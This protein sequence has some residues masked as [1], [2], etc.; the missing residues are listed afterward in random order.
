MGR[1][2][3]LLALIS[4]SALAACEAVPPCYELVEPF[5]LTA[6][7]GATELVPGASVRLTWEPLDAN[8]ANVAFVLVEGE[9]LVPGGDAPTLAGMHEFSTDDG[10]R[11]IA[12]AVYRIRGVFGGCALSAPAY[13][14]GPTRLVFAQGVTFTDTTLTITAADLPLELSFATVS[15]SSF[16]LELLVD[17][18]PGGATGDELTFATTTVPGELVEMTR[19]LTFDGRTTTGAAIPG[20]TYRVI[21]R[22]HAR[23]DVVYDT[24]GPELTWTP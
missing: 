22:V 2:A 20:G 13:E 5:A 18:T 21:A 23:D 19:R 17:P 4:T 7:T 16:D 9:R 10:G 15:L 6:P 11:P 8:G 12:P 14:A 3:P 24:T 1:L